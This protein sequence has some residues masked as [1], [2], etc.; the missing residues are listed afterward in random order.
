MTMKV[1]GAVLILISCGSVGFR[2]AAAQRREERML[3]EL[4]RLL[5]YMECELRYR[6]TPLPVLCA[7]TA[8]QATGALKDLFLILTQELENQI[9]P[10]AGSCMYAA[11]SRCRGLPQQ[12]VQCLQELG[13]TL[14]T[15][16]IDGQ[17]K[18]LEASQ[19]ACKRSLQVLRQNKDNRLR[20]YQT[21]GLC[22]GAAIVILFI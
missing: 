12:V 2:I 13:K 3:E 14:G 6:L 9:S 20:S 7:A 1:I 5:E 15:F 4:C 17:V 16:D 21:L 19:Q 8:R 18:G 11:L 22:A 10:D